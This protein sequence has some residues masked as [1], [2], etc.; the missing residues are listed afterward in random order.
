MNHPTKE[1]LKDFINNGMFGNAI[2]KHDLPV[3]DKIIS[4]G[5]SGT[6]TAYLPEMNKFAIN[7][8]PN[9]WITFEMSEDE[10]NEHFEVHLKN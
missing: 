8:N 1:E 9:Y 10:F 5:E 6:I 4:K 7:F 2:L 3:Y